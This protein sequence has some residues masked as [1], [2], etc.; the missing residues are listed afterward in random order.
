MAGR[1]GTALAAFACD[2]IGGPLGANPVPELLAEIEAGGFHDGFA[3]VLKLIPR[4][5][6]VLVKLLDGPDGEWFAAFGD[7]PTFLR[8]DRAA[9]QAQVDVVDDPPPAALANLLWML[10]PRGDPDDFELEVDFDP[11]G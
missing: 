3:P 9:E 11:G 2:G 10:S 6:V 5:D 4:G 8:A 1:D 7:G